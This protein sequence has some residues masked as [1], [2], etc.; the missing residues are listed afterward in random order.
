MQDLTA[1]F[2]AATA[3]WF[4]RAFSA[5]TGVQRRGWPCIAEGKNTLMLAPTGSGKTLAAFLSAIDR[6]SQ[7][8]ADTPRGTRVIYISPIKALAYDVERNLYLPLAGIQRAAE[9]LGATVRVPTVAVRTGDTSQKER[10]RQARQPDD[11][12]VTTPE[13]LSLLLGSKARENFRTVDTIILDEIHA[14]AGSKRGVHLALTLERLAALADKDP[15]RVGLSA[16]QRPLSE[17]AKFLGGD[18]PVEIVDASAPAA[19]DLRVVVPVPDMSRPP[20][21]RPPPTGGSLLAQDDHS[22]RRRDA[23]D[24]QQPGPGELLGDPRIADAAPPRQPRSDEGGMWGAIHDEVVSLIQQHRST[25]VFVNSRSR[26]ERLAQRLNERLGADAPV[27]AHHGSVSRLQRQEI[28]EGLKDGTL[29]A[30]VATSSLELGVDMGLVDLVVQISAPPSVA[31]GM[32]RIGRAGHAVGETSI[33]RIFPR[34]KADLLA[35]VAVARQM[36]RGYVEPTAIPKNCLD[37]LAQQLV[38]MCIHDER[39][40]DGAHAL[41]RRARPFADLSRDALVATLEMLTGRYPAE[42]FPDLKPRIVWDRAT[43]TLKT[44]RDAATLSLMNVGTIPDRGTY[45]VQHGHEGPRVGELHEGMVLQ[46]RPGQTFVLGATT[47]RI[48]EIKRDR[49]VVEAAPGEPGRLPFW[50]G[51]GPGRPVDLGREMGAFVRELAPLERE[52]AAAQLRAEGSL[53]DNAIENLLDYIGE[54]KEATEVLPTDTEIVIERFRDEL[55]DWR[56]CILSPFGTRIHAPWATAIE[57]LLSEKAGHVVQTLW[58]DDGVVVRMDETAEEAPDISAL[59]PDPEELEE[60]LLGQLSSTPLFATHFRENAARALL[61]PRR[62]TRK[63]SPLWAQRLRAQSLLSAVEQYPA[64]P[65]VLETYREL[66]QDVF[67]LPG[68]K[69]LLRSIRRR[70]VR[71]TEVETPYASPFARSLAFTYVTA[72]L[73]EGDRPAAER[74]AQ[75]LSLDRRLLSELLGQAE[76]RTLLDLDVIEEFEAEK[77]SLTL[78][79]RARNPD[80]L[81]DLLRRLGDLRADEIAQRTVEDPAAWLASLSASK[82]VVEMRIGNEPRYVIAE[83]IATYRDALGAAPP[84]GTPAALLQ[85][86]DRPL[87]RL[88]LRYAATRGPFLTEQLAARYRLMPAQVDAVLRGLEARDRLL[89]GELRPDGDRPE[90]CAPESLRRIRRRTLAKLR[91]QVAPVDGHVLARFLSAW[92]RIAAPASRLEAAIEQLEGVA[93]PW[94]TLI[95]DIL[96]ARVRGF[97]PRMLDELGAMGLIVWLGRGPL[98]KRDGKVALYRRERVAFLVDPP[99][100]YEPASPMHAQILDHLTQRGAAFTV[101][102]QSACGRPPLAEVEAALWDLAWDGRIT[103]DTF[104]PL[105]NLGRR[106]GRSLG[107]RWSLA[108]ELLMHPPTPTEK[109]AARAWLML[110]RYGVLSREAAHAEGWAGGFAGFY[111]VLKEMEDAGRVRRGWFVDGL[112]GAQ[113]ALPGAVE[114]LRAARDAEPETVRIAALDPANPYGS[115]LPWPALRVDGVLRRVAGASVVLVGGV[116]ALYI[117]KGGTGV[118][119][120]DVEDEVLRAGIEGLKPPP[121]RRKAVLIKKIDGQPAREAEAGAAFRAAGFVDVFKGLEFEQLGR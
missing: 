120:F 119:C 12:L 92:H 64:F 2:S 121:S 18:R 30:I 105:L 117:D 43:D 63:R 46:S 17:I 40:V 73:S 65:I 89:L 107:G 47:W 100:P 24:F 95:G 9:G 34:S 27:R 110:E 114:R 94:S 39:T 98:G 77:Q 50:R 33:G 44:R 55:G 21:H 85:P 80:Q 60:L 4:G 14:I 113:F 108:A 31:S 78:N 41:I 103:N 70:E 25:I 16:T 99:A 97:H 75:A 69:A 19:M 10:R 93:L 102:I 48:L 79:R 6:L 91:A 76:L 28:E 116:P 13:S 20:L 42:D 111:G 49:V 3:D 86:A 54:Q 1:L 88:F 57:S 66:L 90:W 29:R 15:Q 45:M 82:R 35:A 83:D 59:L 106:K 118:R 101:M 36:K 52:A 68:L 74:K 7:L 87:E 37:V 56:I 53:D 51:A 32:Q 112:G 38:A 115:L 61:L 11:I 109:L 8:P 72:F 96:P 104:Q 23:A 67:D 22:F 71:I 84:Q 81:Y 5:P 58:T 62:T 26:C